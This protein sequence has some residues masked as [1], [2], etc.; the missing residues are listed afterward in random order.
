[1]EYINP[2]FSILTPSFN[3]EKYVGYFIESI[4]AQSFKNFELII[5]DDCSSDDNIKQIQKYQ[6][7]RITLLQHKYN[8]GINAS[9]NTAFEHSKGEY[10]VFCASDD[11]LQPNALEELDKTLQNH[12]TK[13]IYSNL[14]IIDGNN[15]IT[16][17]ASKTHLKYNG[18]REKFLHTIF[19]SHNCLLSPGLCVPRNI[20]QNMYPLQYAICNM[21]D[22]QIHI[23]ILMQGD[24]LGLDKNL[25]LYR[26]VGDKKSI[27]SQDT[28]LVREEAEIEYL[29]NTFLNIKDIALI[30]QIFSNEIQTRKIKPYNDTL[31]FFLGVMALQ[32]PYKI[33][34]IWGYH[35]IIDF[36]NKKENM[37]LLYN[38]YNFTFKDYI[39]FSNYLK[40][41]KDMQK[42]RDKY[43][44]YKKYFKII[45]Y[46]FIPTFVSLCIAIFFIIKE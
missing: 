30:E 14:L 27:S 13:A 18:K 15:K 46:T 45:L 23:N 43:K 2:R 41:D 8:Q 44:K 9:L 33:R 5:V 26:M 12:P 31:P 21:Q 42:Y 37:E 35:K 7:S 36:Y 19:L 25:I 22:V 6:D 20:F 29:L 11:M 17:S 4:L 34:Q 16:G 10:L 3:H 28:A 40:Q 1:M 24:I 39:E 32:S 38:K